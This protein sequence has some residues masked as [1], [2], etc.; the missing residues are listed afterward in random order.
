M[1]DG[2]VS[3]IG[4]PQC[5]LNVAANLIDLVQLIIKPWLGDINIGPKSF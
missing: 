5:S 3:R 2:M 1:A 4:P